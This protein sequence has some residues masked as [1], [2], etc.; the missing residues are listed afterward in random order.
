[1]PSV[2]VSTIAVVK[3]SAVEIRKILLVINF[4]LWSNDNRKTTAILIEYL[5]LLGLH[6]NIKGSEANAGV[7]VESGGSLNLRKVREH[8]ET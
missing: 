6:E 2:S 3:H 4:L 8:Y 1:M 7:L 5:L